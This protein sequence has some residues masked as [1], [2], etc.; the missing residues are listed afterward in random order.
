M[1]DEDRDRQDGT[2]REPGMM[3]L[4]RV[5]ENAYWAARYLE[6]AEATA[7]LVK[8]HTELYVDLPRSAGLT[9]GPLLTVTGSDDDYHRLHDHPTEEAVVSFLLSDPSHPGSVVASVAQA[10]EDL[11]VTRTMVPRRTWETVNELHLWV[12]ETRRDGIDRGQ[13][14]RRRPT[15]SRSLRRRR[16]RCPL[17]LARPPRT[18]PAPP[19]ALDRSH[20]PDRA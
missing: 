2:S 16:S 10:R 11:R 7:R 3:L 17:A 13:H 18:D 20:R 4:S 12:R 15:P 6:R 19:P 5:A 14:P 1:S 9:W 8:A